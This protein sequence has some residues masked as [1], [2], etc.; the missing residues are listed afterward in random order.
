MHK[1][2]IIISLCSGLSCYS[3]K[4]IKLQY[5]FSLNDGRSEQLY[6]KKN[7]ISAKG[8]NAFGY[9][10]HFGAKTINLGYFECYA[11]IRYGSEK[12]RFIV[13]SPGNRSDLLHYFKNNSFSLIVAPGIF[14]NRRQKLFITLALTRVLRGGGGGGEKSFGKRSYVYEYS[15][16]DPHWD[17]R[18]G[19]KW[20]IK[21]SREKDRFL[22]LGVEVPLVFHIGQVNLNYD[23]YQAAP[24]YA[25][26]S[27]RATFFYAG[28]MLGRYRR[29]VIRDELDD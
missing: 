1:L 21:L 26:L 19:L 22:E 6:K 18:P 13:H 15:S 16:I 8:I 20:Q 5:G 14:L 27:Y 12:N 2:W 9:Y 17:F 10:L 3:Q 24:K 25:D 23:I 7:G 11:G 29:A 28:M 4:K